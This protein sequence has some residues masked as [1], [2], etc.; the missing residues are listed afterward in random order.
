MKNNSFI[1]ISQY[2][3]MLETTLLATTQMYKFLEVKLRGGKG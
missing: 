2:S 3:N 1:L